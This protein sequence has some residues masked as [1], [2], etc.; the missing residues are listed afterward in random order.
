MTGSGNHQA[1]S[2]GAKGMLE[3][4]RSTAPMQHCL[5]QLGTSG[6]PL[7]DGGEALHS[8]MHL[9]KPRLVSFW[10]GGVGPVSRPCILT[11]SRP[12]LSTTSLSLAVS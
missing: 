11:Q 9:Q 12:C 8:C 1:Q 7:L 4:L 3:P 2:V 6:G 10:A 5:G